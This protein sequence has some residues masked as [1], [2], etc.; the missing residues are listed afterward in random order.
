M[1]PNE[2]RETRERTPPALKFNRAQSVF[3]HVEIML[4]VVRSNFF[5]HADSEISHS[6]NRCS[7]DLAMHLS[8]LASRYSVV[9]DGGL[10]GYIV[11]IRREVQH[12]RGVPSIFTD[13]ALA[14]GVSV[15]G[16]W[17]NQVLDDE[18]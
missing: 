14:R 9:T 2:R 16:L 10:S 5:G 4:Q 6:G 17:G 1:V 8:Q 12:R 11:G 7:S 18:R 15:L 13:I 3:Q